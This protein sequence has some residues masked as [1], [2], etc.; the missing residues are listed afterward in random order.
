MAL[1]ALK[2]CSSGFWQSRADMWPFMRQ[3]LL[4]WVRSKDMILMSSIPFSLRISARI[5]PLELSTAIPLTSLF[6]L[7]K[8]SRR[9]R[10]YPQACWSVVNVPDAKFTGKFSKGANPPCTRLSSESF[11]SNFH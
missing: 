11:I 3:R 10:R 4:L 1:T 8:S 2:P 9:P 6:T 5:Y 7:R